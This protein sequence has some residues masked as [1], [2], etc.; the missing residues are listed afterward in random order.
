MAELLNLF[1]TYNNKMAVMYYWWAN[2]NHTI[3]YTAVNLKAVFVIR[4]QSKTHN[5][6]R[7]SS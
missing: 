6:L 5:R 7:T 4:L 1:S 3:T 2:V